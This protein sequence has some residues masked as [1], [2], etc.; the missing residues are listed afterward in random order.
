M[1]NTDTAKAKGYD[2]DK[3]VS[4]IKRHLA[5]DSQGLIHAVALTTAN[6]TDRAGAIQAMTEYQENLS[7]VQSVLVD[8]SYTG[9]PFAQAV[10]TQ[11]GATVQV[12]KRSQ[13]STFA[14]TPKRWVV[15]RTFAWLEKCRR[16]W[17][18]PERNLNTSLQFVVLAHLVML[19]KRS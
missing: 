8:G 4:G 14:V 9:Q 7:W 11:L 12:A 5:V 2:A 18:N 6:V 17:K 3:K 19:L 13:L 16:L 15:E 10:K 1:K